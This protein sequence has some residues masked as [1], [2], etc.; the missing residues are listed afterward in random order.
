MKHTLTNRIILLPL[1]TILFS[2]CCSKNT[3][4]GEID[5][6]IDVTAESTGSSE[7]DYGIDLFNKQAAGSVIKD[8]N[9][10][11]SKNN[12][13]PDDLKK[14][15]PA[16]RDSWNRLL[17]EVQRNYTNTYEITSLDNLTSEE[18]RNWRNKNLKD[19]QIFFLLLAE[20]RYGAYPYQTNDME[21][22]AGWIE[23]ANPKKR[24]EAYISNAIKG[25]CYSLSSEKIRKK[26]NPI[27]LPDSIEECYQ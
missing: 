24:L 21:K 22:K 23:K 4:Q 19:D 20:Y 9:L 3:R 2:F 8:I 17:K 13:I 11:Y 15:Y 10:V 26:L 27:L 6:K 5:S 7:C 16:A 25:N 1:V 12:T 14:A 18:I